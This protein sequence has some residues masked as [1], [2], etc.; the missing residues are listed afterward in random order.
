M[1][2]HGFYFFVHIVVDVLLA[3]ASSI[4]RVLRILIMNNS[5]PL[6]QQADAWLSENAQLL[7]VGDVTYSHTWRG[8][9][10]FC[11]IKEEDA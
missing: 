6:P 9:S 5:N 11:Y 3:F 10:L 2:T 1:L 8:E 4:L 7:T